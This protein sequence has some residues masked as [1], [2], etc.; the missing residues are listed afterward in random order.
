MNARNFIAAA[1][2]F[3]C[4]G[5]ACA[6]QSPEVAAAASA[7]ASPAASASDLIGPTRSA[8]ARTPRADVKAEALEFVKNYRT[9][10][11]VQLDQYRN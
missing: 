5:A 7:G 2:V 4:T 6:A 10:L 9:T 3:V 1:A 8:P 11:A